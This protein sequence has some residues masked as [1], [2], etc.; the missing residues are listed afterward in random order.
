MSPR[1]QL[2]D[3]FR[4]HLN[5]ERG[6]TDGTIYNYVHAGQLLLRTLEH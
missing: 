2:W 6:L 1:E 5:S 3:C 4:V